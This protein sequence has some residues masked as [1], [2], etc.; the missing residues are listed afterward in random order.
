MKFRSAT[1]LTS[2]LLTAIAL[3]SPAFAHCPSD[4]NADGRTDGN[5]LSVVLAGWGACAS[6]SACSGDINDDGLVNG[7]DLTALLAGWGPCVAV[8]AWATLIQA[9]PDPAV[10]HDAT[11]RAAIA[12]TGLAW[13]VRDTATQIE[14]LLIPPGAFQRGCSPTTGGSCDADEYP[15]RNIELTQPFYMGRYEVTQGQWTAAMGS[16]PSYF[17]GSGFPDAALHPVERVSWNLIQQFLAS[18]GL[19]LPTEAEWEFACR[20]GTTTAFHGFSGFPAGTNE[21]SLL[22]S[23]AWWGGGGQDGNSQ[24]RTHPIGLRLANGFGLHDMNGNVWEWV[25]DW[26]SATYY[27]SAPAQN[28]SGPPTG[29][30]KIRRGGGWATMASSCRA[31]N[32]SVDRPDEDSFDDGFRVARNP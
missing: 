3:V 19:R 31:S 6:G 26:Y 15:V 14:F 29:T 25:S 11:L 13:R 4:L 10:V 30:E 5:D 23:I 24:Q 27:Q 20:A 32:R 1:L 2:S 16:N 12:A 22:G 21:E 8:P 18:T 28:P 7:T 9:Y 17:Q